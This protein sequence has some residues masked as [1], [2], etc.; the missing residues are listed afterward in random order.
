[1]G[2]VAVGARGFDVGFE[3]WHGELLFRDSMSRS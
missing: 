1:L 2:E 3:G